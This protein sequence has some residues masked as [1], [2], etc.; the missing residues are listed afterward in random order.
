MNVFSAKLQKIFNAV[1]VSAIKFILNSYCIVSN[2]VNA[3]WKD[4]NVVCSSFLLD[5]LSSSCK[6]VG[7]ARCCF[8]FSCK[9]IFVTLNILWKN[10]IQCKN[11]IHHILIR[12]IYKL[13]NLKFCFMKCIFLATLVIPFKEERIICITSI[14]FI[15]H[16]E[17]S[18]NLFLS[19]MHK[20][21]RTNSVLKVNLKNRIT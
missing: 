7:N 2:P 9:H 13:I 8:W 6:I 14:T 3:N 19:S 10:N 15:L 21:L 11:V 12:L 20:A 18:S 17:I 16:F 1:K 4:G 5:S